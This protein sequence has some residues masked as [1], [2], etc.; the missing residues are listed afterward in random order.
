M[1]TLWKLRREG[2]RI[3][4]FETKEEDGF[5]LNVEGVILA[6]TQGYDAL[7]LCNPN[8]PT[9]ILTEKKDLLRIL[10]QTEREKVWFILDEAFIDFI[11]EESLIDEA[12]AASRLVILRSLTKFF[13]LPGLRAGYLVSNP[14]VIQYFSRDK[15]PWRVN[16]LAQMAAVESL[17]DKTYVARTKEWIRQ[18][19]KSL[20]QGLRGDPGVYSLSEYRQLF[21]RPIASHFKPHCCRTPGKAD[22]PGDSHP[23]LLFLPSPRPLLL[24]H[25][26]AQQEGESGPAQSV[27]S[28]TQGNCQGK[29]E[30]RN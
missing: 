6:L 22:S 5:E 19:R 26:R 14:E 18:E 2:C 20:T 1:K 11:P 30:G 9:G 10:A 17:Q 13:A 29:I 15:E 28:G 3:H 23:R 16:A 27:A 21:I 25:R 12:R 8:N 4:Y 7:Y 24:P